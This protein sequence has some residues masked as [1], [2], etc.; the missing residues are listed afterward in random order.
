MRLGQRACNFAAQQPR[1]E[2]Q[3]VDE[4][5]PKSDLKL[6]KHKHSSED[7]QFAVPCI[8]PQINDGVDDDVGHRQE[9]KA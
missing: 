4:V 7:G 5:A 3:R 9:V 8:H 2:E 6:I 1:N